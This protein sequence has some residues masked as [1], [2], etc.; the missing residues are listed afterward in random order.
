MS[1]NYEST[2]DDH[3]FKVVFKGLK[4]PPEKIKDI[5]KEIRRTA[6]DAIATIDLQASCQINRITNGKTD[7]ITVEVSE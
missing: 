5:E 2:S 1:Q 4:L 3:E 7:G 6:L